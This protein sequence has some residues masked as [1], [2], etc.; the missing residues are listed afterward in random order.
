[1]GSSEVARNV[2]SAV[3]RALFFYSYVSEKARAT[4]RE[5][6]P[7]SRGGGTESDSRRRTLAKCNVLSMALISAYSFA[8]VTAA[9]PSSLLRAAS[10][11]PARFDAAA[12]AAP[13]SEDAAVDVA[14]GFALGASGA[15]PRAPPVFSRF[16]AR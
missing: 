4:R 1:M 14:V 9:S 8:P 12:A 13:P 6:H 15:A 16:T 10:S 7:G 11:S 5:S 2:G 3:L